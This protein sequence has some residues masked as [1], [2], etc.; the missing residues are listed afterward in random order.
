LNWAKIRSIL[1]NVYISIDFLLAWVYIG[2]INA[3][4]SRK[5][6]WGFH[7]MQSILFIDGRNFISKIG[8]ILNP[9]KDR[10]KNIDFSTYDFAGLFNKVLGGIN[11]DKKWVYL[12]R[13]VQHDETRAKSEELIQRQRLLKTHLEKQ[14]F[15]VIIAG[16]V[17]GHIEKCFKGHETLTFKEKGVD[18][19]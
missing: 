11:I 17:R 8:F 16:R 19:T 3:P 12:G 14:G 13:I 2:S 18:V 4:A 6:R 9:A 7:F 5:V 10:S 15:E 1:V